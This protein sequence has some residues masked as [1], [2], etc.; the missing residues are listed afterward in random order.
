MNTSLKFSDNN[1]KAKIMRR[2]WY[3]FLLSVLFSRSTVRGILVGF[4]GVLFVH[5]V[6]LHNIILN[7]LTI[8]LGF[9]PRYIWQV[10]KEAAQNGEFLTL[11]SLGILVF[12]LLSFRLPI[13]HGGNKLREVQVV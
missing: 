13:W 10:I 5:L 6:S 9:L 7:L 4:S 2:V 1:L 12:S 3:S 11:V 8:Q